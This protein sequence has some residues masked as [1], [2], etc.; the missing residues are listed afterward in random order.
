[1][2]TDDNRNRYFR[3]YASVYVAE[4]QGNLLPYVP[5]LFPVIE[6]V[7]NSGQLGGNTFVS[8]KAPA[9]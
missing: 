4:S 6:L 7:S 1:M 8:Q 3:Y 2:H 5:Q 9:S